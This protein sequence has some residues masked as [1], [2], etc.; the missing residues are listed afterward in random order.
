MNGDLSVFAF[1]GGLTYY[2]MPANVY[3]AGSV[4]FGQAVFEDYRGAVDGSDLGLGVNLMVGKEWWVGS[5]WGLGVAGQGIILATD[6]EF[7]GNI[8]AF[9]TN[10]LF[11]ATYN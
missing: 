7:L 1:G 4:G 2:I 11:S 9:S 8:T 3:L 10:I 6:D 5:D